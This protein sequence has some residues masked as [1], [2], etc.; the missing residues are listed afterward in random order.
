VVAA[1]CLI[2][3][4]TTLALGRDSQPRTATLDR[5]RETGQIR[6]GYRLDTPPFSYRDNSGQTGGYAVALCQRIV[7]RLTAQAG[8]AG[9]KAEW[10]PVTAE[11]RFH[12]LAQNRIDL[13]C[14]ADTVTLERRRAVSF[15]LPIFPGGIGVLV[16]SDASTRLQDVLSGR[17]Q[18]AYPTWRASATQALQARP[19]SVVAGTTTE[20]WLAGRIRDLDVITSVSPVGGY[21]AGVRAVFDRESD[22]FFGER[23]VLLDL[24]KRHA[25]GGDLRVLS[26]LFTYEPLALALPRDDED[27]RLLVDRVLSHIYDTEAIRL[28]SQ[29]FGQPDESTITFFRWTALPD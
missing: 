4:S 3:V 2:A 21:D 19:F 28:Y 5:I 12:A 1:I 18:S 6:L 8:L 27:F 17:G 24:A 20:P 10:V 9:T 23:A 22:A 16:R 7:D 14:S 29:W 26:R 13:L 11:E 25:S 15:S